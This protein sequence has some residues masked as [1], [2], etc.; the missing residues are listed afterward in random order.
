MTFGSQASSS[1]VNNSLPK[2]FVRRAGSVDYASKTSLYEAL[3]DGEDS[4]M[5]SN[6]WTK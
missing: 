4:W 6:A 5:Q 2:C 3:N 1:K